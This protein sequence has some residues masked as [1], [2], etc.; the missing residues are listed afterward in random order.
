MKP[1]RRKFLKT[2]LMGAVGSSFGLAS[3]PLFS[4]A[5]AQSRVRL[6]IDVLEARNFASLRNRRVGLLTHP[7]GVN[8]FGESTIQVLQRGIGKNLNA[9]FGPEHGIYGDEKANVSIE[10]RTDSRTGLPV[11]SLYGKYRKPTPAMLEGIDTMVIDL[12][13]IG[14][15]S[16]TFISCMRYVMEACFELGKSVIVL[17]R[18]NPLG[19]LKRDGPTMES[20][21]KSYVGAF[22][23]PYVHG[24]TIG[25]IARYVKS[26]P[27]E[28]D[29]SDSERRQGSLEIIPMQGWTR[30]MRWPKTGLKWIPTSPAIPDIA[31][32]L[33]Y[34]MIGLGTQIGGF[35]HGFGSSY[36]FRVLQFPGKSPEVITETLQSR[37]ISGL[38]FKVIPFEIRG[39]QR[40]G[41]Y[42]TLESWSQWRPAEIS[43]HLMAL[44]CKWSPENPFQKAPESK[45]SLFNKHYGDSR[46]FEALVR[47]G[48]QINIPAFLNVWENAVEQF[49]KSAAKF[50]IYT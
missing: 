47:N 17:D 25:E 40:R 24:L 30:D 48:S 49:S 12:Q 22:Q 38:G 7:A 9:L 43:L 3:Q 35:Q 18:P 26:T 34:A 37:R 21:W 36:P 39:K 19:G 14:S 5:S 27:G 29:I 31:A 44:A 23:I 2:C 1:H 46:V 11:F 32:V 41:T 28:L 4:A 13:D 45:K 50:Q 16:Y 6:G 42:V 15:R 8:R 20:H 33:G 10:D